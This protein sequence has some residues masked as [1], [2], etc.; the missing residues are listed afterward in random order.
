M[1]RTNVS[2]PPPCWITTMAGK[3]PLPLGTATYSTMS[4]R[5]TLI[6]SV[7]DGIRIPPL[8]RVLTCGAWSQKT[9]ALARKHI[10][11]HTLLLSARQRGPPRG[12]KIFMQRHNKDLS[13]PLCLSETLVFRRSFDCAF[14]HFPQRSSME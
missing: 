4:W 2:T 14:C 11:H 10:V 5:P 3:G 1:V 7:N 12:V 9:T 8:C 13:N 6:L